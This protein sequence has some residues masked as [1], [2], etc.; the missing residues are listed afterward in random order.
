[1]ARGSFK[2]RRGR[3][4]ARSVPAHSPGRLVVAGFGALILTGTVALLM[5]WA[6]APGRSI[7]VLE[8]LFTSTSA[9]CVTGLAVLDT[10][11]AW[12]GVGQATIMVLIQLGGLGIM[13]AASLIAILV[14]H[15][16]GLAS[17]LVTASERGTVL[18]GDIRGT[19][20]R[21]VT[22]TAVIE[23][24]VATVLAVR[25]ATVYGYSLPKAV[26]HGVFHS[27]SA[28]NNAGF[29]L[30]SDSIVSFVGDPVVCL[31]IAGAVILGGIGYPVI[32]E[33]VRRSG[34]R[35]VR[36][37][38]WSL[39]SRLT[40]WYSA[41]LL[42]AG[43]VLVAGV[44]WDRPGT[45]GP[46]SVP[47][48]LLA[49]VFQSAITRTAGFNSV[50]IGELEPGTLFGM[51]LLM[52]IGAGSA[53]TAG[54]VKVTTIA[55]LLAAIRAQVQGEPDT[56]LID[57][58]LSGGTVRLALAVVA[59]SLVAVVT[60]TFAI[61]LTSH[62]TLDQVLFEVVSAFGTVGL[63]TGITPDLASG[64]QLVVI[65][66]MFGGRVGM[67]GF[68]TALSIPRRHALVRPPEGRPLVG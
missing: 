34:T 31:A 18:M 7:S 5:P 54:G 30:Y 22:I 19:V 10:A 9:V 41:I 23:G 33:I 44:E 43:T 68:I 25:F 11:T 35:E 45:L 12:S 40:V 67:L 66:L 27:V 42:L 14:T 16:L 3:L 62:W 29:A 24:T 48:K 17:R 21:V 36:R 59:T 51:D 60:A 50:P 65:M 46:L 26:W 15:R 38:S 6:H 53:G 39:H 57:R 4:S 56:T 2:T 63:S 52:F 55:V 1:M 32:I 49:A 58:R 28:F 47:T 13:T 61:V 64:H 37:R 20:L 8:A